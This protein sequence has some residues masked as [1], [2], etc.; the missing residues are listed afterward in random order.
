MPGPPP[1]TSGAVPG[2]S[3]L[4][5]W[6]LS[7]AFP[8]AAACVADPTSWPAWI[9]VADLGAAAV[10]VVLGLRHAGA[11]R[12]ARPAPGLRRPARA[13]LMALALSAAALS[14][15]QAL[16]APRWEAAAFGLGWRVA[17][18]ACVSAARPGRRRG[19]P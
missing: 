15:L 13:L 18:L 11:G 12:P 10:V 19:P 9:G 2:A 8:I 17:L 5:A 7:C 4:L 14:L 3:F 16:A 6:T 1:S